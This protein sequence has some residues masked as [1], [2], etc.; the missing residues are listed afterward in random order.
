MQVIGRNVASRDRT[1]GEPLRPGLDVSV[2][3]L[4]SHT[5]LPEIHLSVRGGIAPV[6]L[7]LY[8]DGELQDS[9]VSTSDRF[10]VGLVGVG[11]GRHAVTARAI[12]ASGRW[13]GASIVVAASP[14]AEQSPVG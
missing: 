8:V 3:A 13:G 4:A 5:G 6:R 9:Q 10:R 7:F 1:T 12:D 14:S 2:L 11:A